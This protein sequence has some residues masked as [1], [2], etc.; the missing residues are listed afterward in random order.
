[1]TQSAMI[2]VNDIRPKPAPMVNINGTMLNLPPVPDTFIITRRPNAL[3]KTRYSVKL[4][5][6]LCANLLKL[7]LD[8]FDVV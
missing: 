2:T 6:Y 1:M 5:L 7:K 4:F 3:Y 8:Y